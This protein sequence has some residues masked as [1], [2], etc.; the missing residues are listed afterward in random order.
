M[1]G[2]QYVLSVHQDTDDFHAHVIA[3][4][5]GRDGKANDLWNERIIR[6]RICAEIAAERGWEIV[7]GHHNRDIVRRVEKQHEMPEAPARR[8]WDGEYRRL[9]ERG[10]MPWQEIA[11]PYVLDAVERAQSWEE[12]HRRLDAH[13]VV[14]KV[15]KRGDRVQGLAFAEGTDARAPGCGASRIDKRCSLFVLEARFGAFVPAHEIGRNEKGVDER[16]RVERNATEEKRGP[17]ESGAGRALHE[18][19]RIVDHARMRSEYAAYRRQFFGEKWNGGRER[20]AAAWNRERARRTEEAE[21]RQIARALLKACVRILSRGVVRQ[22]GYYTADAQATRWQDHDFAAARTRWEAEKIGLHAERTRHLGEKPKD[23]RLFV[24]ERARAGDEGARRVVADLTRLRV[25][26][27]EPGNAQDA[28]RGRTVTIEEVRSRLKVIRTEESAHAE[29]VRGERDAVPRVE[30][31]DDLGEVLARRREEI[32]EEAE[33]KTDFTDEERARLKKL[34]TQKKSWNPFARSDA[35]DAE[36]LLHAVRQGR[37]EIVRNEMIRDFEK[38]EVPYHTERIGACTSRYQ[39]YV[40]TSF[41]LEDEG[42]A[43]Q[44]VVDWVIPDLE[45]RLNVIERSGGSRIDGIDRDATCDE[46]TEALERSYQSIPDM[47][48][49]EVESQMRTERW[50]RDR[51]RGPSMER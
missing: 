46:I 45:E 34:E 3:N 7:V 51:A 27:D 35:V 32:A 39:E 47:L 10:E 13:G 15:V 22:L 11:R 6:E 49:A 18:A 9:H 29:R 25:A 36:N 12:L 42:H 5:I 37:Y 48:R 43:A 16:L 8:L 19:G 21:K 26:K 30:D 38:H 31:P 1:R 40:R 28:A 24:V 2:H 23:Y 4:R 41:H 50:E 33:K 20:Y 14:A 17:R 44:R